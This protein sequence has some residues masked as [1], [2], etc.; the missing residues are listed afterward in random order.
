MP[1]TPVQTPPAETGLRILPLL[2]IKEIVVLPHVEYPIVVGRSRSMAAVETALSSEDKLLIVFTQRDSSVDLPGQDDLHPVGTRSLIRRMERLPNGA[3]S[4]SLRGLDRV[5][6]RDLDKGQNFLQGKFDVL[7]MA[8]ER[9]SQ[10]E[11]LHRE[12]LEQASELDKLM[13]GNW[14]KGMLSQIIH[15]QASPLDHVYTLCSVLK[16]SK[17]QQQEIL[18][19]TT[20]F[21]ALRLVH[22]YLNHEIQVLS[23]QKEIASQTAQNITKDQRRHLLRRQM[24]Q[25]QKELGE[26]NPQQ[27]EMEE[28]REQLEQA[29][30]PDAA[31]DVAQREL[32][33]LERL[34]P[35]AQEYQLARTYLEL[36]LDLPWNRSTE[37]TLDLTEARKILDEDHFDLKEVKDRIIENLAMYKLNPKS[38][39]AI[40]CFVG[41][42]GVGKTSLGAS[43]ARALGR[44]FERISLGGLHDEAELRGHRRTYIGA[45]PGRVIQAIK[46]TGVNN[47]LIML[48]EVDKLGRD[49]RGDPSAALMEILDPSQNDKFRDNYLDIDFDLSNVFFLT[50]A[51]TLD[52]I[53]R[54][55]LDRM[56]VLRLSGYTEE[57]KVQIAKRYLLPRQLKEVNLD[58][59]RIAISDEI[60]RHV[61]RR[62]TREAGVRELERQ[63]ARLVRKSALP[64]AEGKHEKVTVELDRIIDLLGSERF[65]IENMRKVPVPGVV[66]GLA[67]TEAGGDI[68]FI[69]TVLIPEGKGLILTGQLGDVMKESAQ[70][71]QSY[72]RSQ[73]EKLNIPTSVF[74]DNGVHIHIPAG[75]IPKDGPSAG[76][77][78]ATSLVSLFCG[79]PVRSDT[80][81]TG[82]ITLAGLVMPVG[83]IKEKILAAHRAGLKRIILPNDN[84]KD[85]TEIDDAIK[86]DIEFIPV[87]HLNEVFE[88]GVGGE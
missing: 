56:E 10:V 14:P 21:D 18:E 11:A 16:V 13:E 50:T 82:E 60:L 33:R 25:I 78:I 31:A 2:P 53:P 71:A 86:K 64:F 87:T 37:H 36:I 26:S 32:D 51:N 41:G 80:A 20:V 59:N 72:I 52:T 76:V 38:R 35:E 61:V 22:E 46:R 54:P 12:V 39:G 75:A 15:A 47:P 69:E 63:I 29:D 6:L 34:P 65:F 49:Y 74:K 88:A 55:L 24:E 84:L 85:L 17:E 9:N 4:L 70:A 48:D 23:L 19:A 83:G 7:T 45:M 43:I 77:T 28:W 8:E 73:A 67:W 30:L 44:K 58:E 40:L 3:I 27:A 66:T 42:P 57:E 5:I 79:K 62:Y 68:L 1:E 81:M